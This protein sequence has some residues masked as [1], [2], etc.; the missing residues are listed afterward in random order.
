E[1]SMR[2]EEQ[3]QIEDRLAQSAAGAKQK[4]DE[5]PPKPSVPIEKRMDRFELHMHEAGLNEHGSILPLVVK[6]KLELSH[7]FHHQFRRRRNEY[8]VTRPSAADP[9]LTSAKL[10][11]RLVTAT[12]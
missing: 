5:Q 11:R 10:A 4:C 3:A 9:V 6:K 7:T 12:S 8:G 1:L 2:L